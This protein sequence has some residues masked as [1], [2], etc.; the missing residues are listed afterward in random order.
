M[1][2]HDVINVLYYEHWTDKQ[3]FFDVQS[4]NDLLNFSIDLTDGNN[5]SIEISSREEKI[6]LYFEI[7]QFLK[8]TESWG[9]QNSHNS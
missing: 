9:R 5:K 7:K 8:W 4:L 6:V 1:L 3:N 2:V